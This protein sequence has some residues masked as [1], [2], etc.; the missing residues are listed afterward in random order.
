[1]NYHLKL[2]FYIAIYLLCLPR[3]YGNVHKTPAIKAL[4]NLAQVIQKYKEQEGTYPK[5]W[6]DFN[7]E[8]LE[9]YPVIINNA[10]TYLDVEKRYVFFEKP[11]E[12]NIR[13]N[14]L[15]VILMA[16]DC[17]F[18]G[19]R[20]KLLP[21]GTSVDKSVRYMIA[22]HE[23][24][25]ISSL[26]LSEVAIKRLFRIK[27]LDL[28]TYTKHTQASSNSQNNLIIEDGAPKSILK[29]K[30]KSKVTS[31]EDVIKK[32]YLSAWIIALATLVFVAAYLVYIKLQRKK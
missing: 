17:D 14:K 5:S 31:T 4:S 22:I 9:N 11:L 20:I 29:A 16:T 2:L 32:N 25:S 13:G 23:N 10:R 30:R 7:D 21:D 26:N 3:V 19:K 8:M 27:G 18:E 28:E 12:L 24:N 15:R 6:A 1:M